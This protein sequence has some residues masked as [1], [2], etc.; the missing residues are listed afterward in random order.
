MLIKPMKD[1]GSAT[2]ITFLG[3]QLDTDNTEVRIPLEKN[4]VG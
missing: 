3:Q 2:V 4:W 1:Q